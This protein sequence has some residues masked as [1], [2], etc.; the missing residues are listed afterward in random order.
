[1]RN[2][3]ICCL[4][5]MLVENS[6]STP[7]EESLS[8]YRVQDFLVSVTKFCQ[9]FIFF[10]YIYAPM[11]VT[12]L[13]RYYASKEEVANREFHA[14]KIRKE[15]RITSYF[16]KL[17]ISALCAQKELRL[18]FILISTM[19]NGFYMVI[20]VSTRFLYHTVETP[21]VLTDINI[22]LLFVFFFAVRMSQETIFGILTI[23]PSGIWHCDDEFR[24]A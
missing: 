2:F 16:Y 18:N 14:K 10:F 8:E 23:L 3:L 13:Y 17:T 1:M 22:F 4:K 19:L 24:C 20:Y 7:F 9:T 5:F 11:L 21:G 12:G 6:L 15:N